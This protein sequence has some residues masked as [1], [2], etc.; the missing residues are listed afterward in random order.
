MLYHVST[1]KWQQYQVFSKHTDCMKLALEN[2]GTILQKKPLSL[3]TFLLKMLADFYASQ[4]LL[5]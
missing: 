2:Q 1:P 4:Y 5:S 3:E